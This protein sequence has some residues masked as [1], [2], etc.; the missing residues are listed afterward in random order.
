MTGW[1]SADWIMRGIMILMA[2]AG[3]TGVLASLVSAIKERRS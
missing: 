1:Q 2:S 3:V